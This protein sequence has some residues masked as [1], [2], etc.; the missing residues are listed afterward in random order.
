MSQGERNAS[1]LLSDFLQSA[2]IARMSCEN[3]QRNEIWSVL[4]GNNPT[5]TSLSQAP[6][7]GRASCWHPRVRTW[8]LHGDHSARA[9]MEVE[10]GLCIRDV[11]GARNRVCWWARVGVIF[12]LNPRFEDVPQ[13]RV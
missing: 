3:A 8:I 12:F 2:S 1:Q 7:S 5:P 6:P 4:R 9:E 10:H 11:I 13:F